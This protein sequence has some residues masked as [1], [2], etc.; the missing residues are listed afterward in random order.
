VAVAPA[1][2]PAQGGVTTSARTPVNI[3]SGPSGG[4]EVVRVVPRASSLQV[5]GEAPGGWLQVGEGGE[6]WGW[7]HN[8]M[9]ER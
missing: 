8:S 3:R 1:A 2:G 4:T 7:L 9:L 5:F 6:A